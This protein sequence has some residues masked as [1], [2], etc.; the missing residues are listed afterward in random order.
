MFW[1]ENLVLYIPYQLLCELYYL[2][3]NWFRTL[4]FILTISDV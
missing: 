4:Y 3:Y 2:I 1:I